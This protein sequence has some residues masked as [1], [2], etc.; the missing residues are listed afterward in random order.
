MLLAFAHAPGKFFGARR[1]EQE[2]GKPTANTLQGYLSRIRTGKRD[3]VGSGKLPSDLLKLYF[4]GRAEAIEIDNKDAGL[5]FLVVHQ[6]HVA[7]EPHHLFA[8]GPQRVLVGVTNFVLG[9]QYKNVF[10]I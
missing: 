5:L 7:R 4:Q 1:F 2:I 3:E 10:F 9:L 8:K 6:A